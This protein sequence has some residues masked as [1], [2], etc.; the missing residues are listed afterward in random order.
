MGVAPPP[1][2]QVSP[3]HYCNVTFLSIGDVGPDGL[4][5]ERLHRCARCKETYYCGKEQQRSHWKL[6]QFVCC[7]AH[8]ES[9]AESFAGLSLREVV[10]HIKIAAFH[11]WDGVSTRTL[12]Q[13]VYMGR[14]LLFLLKRLEVL[15]YEDPDPEITETDVQCSENLIQV[16]QTLVARSDRSFELFWAIPGMTTFLLN[17]ELLSVT[18]RERKLAAAL[19]SDEELRNTD[20]MDFSLSYRMFTHTMFRFLEASFLV[21]KT[22]LTSCYRENTI[23]ACAARKMMQLYADPYTRGSFPTDQPQSPR[24]SNFPL[25]LA[26]LLD[27]LPDDPWDP[28]ALVPGLTVHEIFQIFITEPGW[29]SD[30]GHIRNSVAFKLLLLSASTKLEAWDAFTVEA[31]AIIA[32]KL[33]GLYSQLDSNDGEDVT[34]DANALTQLIFIVVGYNFLTKTK[35]DPMWLKVVE[36]AATPDV[37]PFAGFFREWYKRVASVHT[38]GLFALASD[39]KFSMDLMPPPVVDHVLEYAMDPFC[40]ESQL[41]GTLPLLL[42]REGLP[43]PTFGAEPRRRENLNK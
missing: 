27:Y 21:F 35:D 19:P 3:K 15:Y 4:P 42:A 7:P 43:F 38:K 34:T 18:M 41:K 31:R 12:A 9:P 28:K 26:V 13:N 39:A 24:V 36:H 29:H 30:M 32:H 1:L 25:A 10:D 16:L 33:L 20:D 8:E 17:L 22:D 37:G 5:I 14:P 40:Y 23:A 2:A 6:H 11:F